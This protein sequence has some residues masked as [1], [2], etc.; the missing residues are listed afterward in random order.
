MPGHAALLGKAW[1]LG[2]AC[3]W[4]RLPKLHTALVRPRLQGSCGTPCQAP[5]APCSRSSF[6]QGPQTWPACARLSHGQALRH[7]KGSTFTLE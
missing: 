1:D 3:L 7:K 6:G 4:F 2:F 5:H